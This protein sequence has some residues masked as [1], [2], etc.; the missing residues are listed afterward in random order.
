MSQ[1]LSYAPCTASEVFNEKNLKT[2]Q[3]GRFTE[4]RDLGVGFMK[5]AKGYVE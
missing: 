1:F 4:L 5:K 2:N 3:S